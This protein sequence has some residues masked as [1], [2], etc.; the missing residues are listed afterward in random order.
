[1][2]TPQQKIALF[3]PAF[4]DGGAERVFVNI[5]GYLAGQGHKIDMLVVKKEGAYLPHV[6][7]GINIIE[8]GGSGM[9]RA[10]GPL[11][12]Y[13]RQDKPAVLMAALPGPN[14]L[15][16][17][18]KF[19]SST[20]VIISQHMHLSADRAIAKTLRSKIRFIAMRLFYR[21]AD[22]IV[23]VSEGLADDFVS[24][25]GVSR[26]RIQVIYNPVFDDNL[27]EKAKEEPDHKWL[28]NKNQPVCLAVGRLAPPKDYKTLL[29]AFADVKDAKL[30]ILGEGPDRK[31]IEE[32]VRS[33]GL[34]DCVSMPSFVDNPYA[35]MARA[36]LFVHSTEFE[37]FGNVLVEA[38]ACGTPVLS[39]DCPSGPAEI[40]ENG[41]YGHLV[42]VA[43]VEAMG[44][45]IQAMIDKKD[46]ETKA[47]QARASCF[48]IQ[49]IGPQY[50]A[51]LKSFY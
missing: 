17:A 32:L 48:T 8:L 27:H 28:K 2:S 3:L 6:P 46:P 29:Q 7:D 43:D 4:N 41:K 11:L 45:A 38:L 13:L 14:L 34:E 26:E 20:K 40:L 21:F 5:A 51:L 24:L 12:S 10:L 1:M 37:G 42:P 49:K 33:L 9:M 35:Y 16:I 47:L 23:C 36:D 31:E 44:K 19:L 15:A 39:T 18:A 50:E 22:G 30:I 25:T